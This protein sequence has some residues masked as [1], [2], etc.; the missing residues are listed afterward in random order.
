MKLLIV[1]Y[2]NLISRLLIQTT[3]IITTLNIFPLLIY[4][5]SLSPSFTIVQSI[6]QEE[7]CD[8]IK[9]SWVIQVRRC[10]IC[11]SAHMMHI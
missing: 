9:K 7:W 5:Y 8:F 6:C 3:L 4:S 10:R 2:E 11:T 1:I